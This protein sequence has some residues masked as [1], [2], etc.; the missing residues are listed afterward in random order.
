MG[1][2]YLGNQEVTPILYDKEASVGI[3]KGVSSQG[4][5]GYPTQS[6][7]FS[8]PSTATDLDKQALYYSFVDCTT[9][10][11]A[12]L[13]SLTAISGYHAASNSFLRC[14]SITSVDLS[15]LT[16]VTGSEALRNAFEQ[17]SSL[18]N[19]DLSSL[20]TVAGSRTLQHVFYNCSAL[21]SIDLSSLA[22]VSGDNCF[23]NAFNGCAFTSVSFDSLSDI[24]GS[25]AFYQI[26]ANCT[27]LT[28]LSFPALTTTSFGSNTTQFNSMLYRCSNVTVHFPAAIQSTIGSWASVADGFGG[29]NTTVLFDL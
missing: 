11:S 4:V 18:S 7:S 26:F 10:S 20:T 1:K 25:A 13:S 12:D 29:T 24:S 19:V 17:C 16:T 2:L 27:N 3:P 6:F 22:T 21:S 9:L 28:T 23:N 14:T 8:L 5:Y 15:S